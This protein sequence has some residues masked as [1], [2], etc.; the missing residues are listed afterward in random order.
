MTLK[1]TIHRR[2]ARKRARADAIRRK[3][4][5]DALSPKERARRQGIIDMFNESSKMWV[6][7]GLRALESDLKFATGNVWKP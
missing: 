3:A 5:W 6:A 1:R 7:E 4:E 2:N